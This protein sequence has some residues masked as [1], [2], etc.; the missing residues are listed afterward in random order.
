MRKLDL[1]V[2]G[3]L[4]FFLGAASAEECMHAEQMHTIVTPES[5]TWGPAPPG[6]PPG[7]NAVVIAGDPSKEGSFTMRAKMPDGYKISP[8]WHDMDEN[9]T[10]LSGTL[11]VGTGD[12]FDKSK[13][14]A[15]AAGSFAMMPAKMHHWGWAE[16]E[17]VIQIH[18]N[19]PFTIT[20]VNAADDPRKP[21]PE[22]K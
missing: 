6:L 18:G 17:T 8:H 10:V 16:G 1:A 20:Y 2:A 5:I 14:D 7:A 12:T 22:A 15:M 21:M 4:L 9:V 3:T 19:G 13:A 11:H